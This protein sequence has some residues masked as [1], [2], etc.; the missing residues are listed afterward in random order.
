MKKKV[1]LFYK[2]NGSFNNAVLTI[3][4]NITEA[5]SVNKDENEIVF[6]MSNRIISLTKG[7]CSEEIEVKEYI[8]GN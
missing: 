1:G 7:R 8:T 5:L 6:S 4:K 2:K 3:D